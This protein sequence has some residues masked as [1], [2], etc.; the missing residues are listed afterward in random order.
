MEIWDVS[1]GIH[2]LIDPEIVV[3]FLVGINSLHKSV[4]ISLGAPLG[5]L[6]ISPIIKRPGNV[7]AQSHLSSANV[8]N[9]WGYNPNA[10]HNL[11][12]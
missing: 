1:V 9:A 2:G 5:V 3:G 8:E 4:Q 11:T 7:A 6:Y 10:P 12:L